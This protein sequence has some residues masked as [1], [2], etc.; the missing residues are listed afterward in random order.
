MRWS[1]LAAVSVSPLMM[2]SFAGLGS[3]QAPDATRMSGPVVHENLAVYFI[4]GKS[5]PG[6]VPLTLEEAMAKGL[7]KLRETSNVNQLE[8][9]NLGAEEVFIP[10]IRALTVGM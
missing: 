3:A 7:V 2:L 8:I 6:K 5:A 4:H 1:L 9:E 10:F